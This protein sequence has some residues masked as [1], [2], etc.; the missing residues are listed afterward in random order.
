MRQ[1][2]L[3][4]FTTRLLQAL[5]SDS[6]IAGLLRNAT[7]YIADPGAYT[8]GDTV[9]ISV[10]EKANVTIH[11]DLE[12][13]PS[14][15]FAKG[16]LKN[17]P[18]ELT[19]LAESN[20][21]MDELDRIISSGNQDMINAFIRQRAMD[22]LEA[23]ENDLY[24]RTFDLASLDSETVG[25]PGDDITVDDLI[26]LEQGIFRERKWKGIINL[27]LAPT[28]M[29]QIK[30]DFKNRYTAFGINDGITMR[31]GYILSDVPNIRIFESTELPT[32]DDMSNIT[33][34]ETTKMAFAF[35][36]ESTAM[37]NPEIR[38]EGDAVGLEVQNLSDSG[39][40][41]Q[42]TRFSDGSKVVNEHFT[43]M[44]SLYGTGI[45][46]PTLVIPIKGGNIG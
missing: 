20:I 3:E 19:A 4:F 7:Q 36:D 31:Q 33:G 18:V 6:V 2:K 21:K 39:V 37:F 15:N 34:S 43:K 30:K 28:R 25:V 16:Q 23:I 13:N 12:A 45:F 46:R 11:T 38:E 9:N 32:I 26:D 17:F 41:Y 40:N 14:I 22:H 8:Y 29:G 10:A 44:L 35:A 27:V 1:Q 5:T 24:T 42:I